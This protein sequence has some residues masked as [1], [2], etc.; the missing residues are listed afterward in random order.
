MTYLGTAFFT[1][2]FLLVTFLVRM[3][4]T[5]LEQAIYLAVAAALMVGTMPH[6]K[7]LALAADYL[8]RTH[9]ERPNPPD[10]RS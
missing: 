1:G 9:W 2:L 8:I 6:R 5:R 4:R 3:P 10:G 7:G